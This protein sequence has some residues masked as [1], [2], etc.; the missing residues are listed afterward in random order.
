MEQD[1]RNDRS[2]SSEDVGY[3]QEQEE[4]HR[5]DKAE[6]V[7]SD[8][9]GGGAVGGISG[10][11]VGVKADLGNLPEQVKEGGRK[12]TDSV[13]RVGERATSKVTDQQDE[14]PNE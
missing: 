5:N 8:D 1:T 7:S 13:R 11:N 14:E 3:V 9:T 10:V 12:L 2:A 4:E 6:S